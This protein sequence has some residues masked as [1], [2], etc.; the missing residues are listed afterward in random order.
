MHFHFVLLQAGSHNAHLTNTDHQSDQQEQKTT[1]MKKIRRLRDG[2]EDFSA[3]E[4]PILNY[5]NQQWA[6]L[7]WLASSYALQVTGRWMV[8]ANRPAGLDPGL[9]LI[10]VMW[11][12]F[13]SISISI[14]DELLF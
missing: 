13:A 8:R 9:N 3:P 14:T 10:L 7:P 2:D 11:C 4:L 5:A 6:V 1:M 12:D